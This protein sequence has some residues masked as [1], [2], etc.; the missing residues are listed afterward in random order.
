MRSFIVSFMLIILFSSIMFVIL[1]PIQPAQINNKVREKS[2]VEK[3]LTEPAP[4]PAPQDMTAKE[5]KDTI[6]DILKQFET[7]SNKR[8][9]PELETKDTQE[10]MQS[11]KANP[12]ESNRIEPQKQAF[13]INT[14]NKFQDLQ[15]ELT[16]K[17]GNNPDA[18][19]S[20]EDIQEVFIKLLDSTQIQKANN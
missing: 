10:K 15:G 19:V 14:N 17:Y 5:K 6:D 1:K 2:N 12:D 18:E 7:D 8:I 9:P 13:N 4:T 20:Q 16:K 3:L 11:S